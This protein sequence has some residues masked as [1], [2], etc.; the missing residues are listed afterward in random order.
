MGTPGISLCPHLPLGMKVFAIA[1][2]RDISRVIHGLILLVPSSQSILARCARLPIS[3]SSGEF[4]APPRFDDASPLRALSVI[5]ATNGSA[6]T[7]PHTHTPLPPP[8]PTMTDPLDA[9]VGAQ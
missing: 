2:D 4:A 3:A 9:G 7:H 6:T 5:V 1:F 8:P